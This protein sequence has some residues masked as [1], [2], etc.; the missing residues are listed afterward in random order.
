MEDDFDKITEGIGWGMVILILIHL[1]TSCSICK[2]CKNLAIERDSIYVERVDSVFVRDT[3]LL[4]QPQDS[5]A[6]NVVEETEKS[7]LETDLATSDAWVEDGQLHHN[8]SN[9]QE[10]V[11]IRVQ[12]PMAISTEKHYLTR[13]V[14]KK[15]NELSA[16]QNFWLI[17][18]KFF[19]VIVS[20]GVLIWLIKRKI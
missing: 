10:L 20:V 16:M 12:M 7:H 4:Y 11:P 9:K 18:G 19:A 14:Y 13:I 5:T 2:Y 15:V 17:L 6:S 3:I 1:F 8:L